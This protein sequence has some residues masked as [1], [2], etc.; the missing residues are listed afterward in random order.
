M[1]NNMIYGFKIQTWK[2]IIYRQRKIPEFIIDHTHKSK[3]VMT[4]SGY[5]ASQSN[6]KAN[7]FLILSFISWKKHVCCR[8]FYSKSGK[9]IWK[10]YINFTDI[11][12]VLVIHVLVNS[13]NSVIIIFVLCLRKESLK[14][15]SNIKD[16]IIIL[17]IIFHVE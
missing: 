3:Q 7:Q 1:Q 13:S 12:M 11:V 14:D 17:M 10:P 16:R 2:S 8:E 15:I 5:Y 6:L 9:Q 4:T